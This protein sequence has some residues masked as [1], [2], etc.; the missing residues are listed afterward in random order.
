MAIKS[1]SWEEI[2]QHFIDLNKK[3][4]KHDRFL[5]LV[6]HIKST[7]LPHR[8]FAYISLDTIVLGN[9]DDLQRGRETLHIQFL[10][11]ENE[12]VFEYF[13]QRLR[14]VE[15]KRRYP[16]EKGAEKFDNFIKMINW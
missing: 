15:F 9:T 2:E 11:T 10:R 6:R 12:W 7:Y 14:P 1:T 3:G 5:E 13:S 8:L 16:A 4:W